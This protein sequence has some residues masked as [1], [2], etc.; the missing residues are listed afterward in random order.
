[1]F[2]TVPMYGLFRLADFVVY[3]TAGEELFRVKRER[4]LPMA[5]FVVVESGSPVC[6]IRQRSILLNR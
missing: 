4:R 5:R 1:M 6:T 3:D 2:V